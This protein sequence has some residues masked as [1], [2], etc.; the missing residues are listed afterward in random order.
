MQAYADSTPHSAL[1]TTLAKAAAKPIDNIACKVRMMAYKMG[2][3]L[4]VEFNS[5]GLTHNDKKI[6]VMPSI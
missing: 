5:F 3:F 6:P 4:L 1:E 2:H